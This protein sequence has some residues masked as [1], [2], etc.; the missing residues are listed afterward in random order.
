VT[1][2]LEVEVLYRSVDQLPHQAGLSVGFIELLL[3]GIGLIKRNIQM[4]LD[5]LAGSEGNLDQAAFVLGILAVCFGDIS[6]N[7]HSRIAN[8]PSQSSI[9]AEDCFFVIR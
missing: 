9:S 1:C 2:D 6:R 3:G 5:L 7:G 8:L 4:A